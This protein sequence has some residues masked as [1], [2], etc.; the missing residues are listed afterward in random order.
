MSQA[1]DEGRYSIREPEFS[2][3]TLLVGGAFWTVLIGLSA[4]SLGMTVMMNG[5][6]E[7][8]AERMDGQAEWK[9][10]VNQWRGKVDAR[11]TEGERK[12]Y[13]LET[14]NPPA[15]GRRR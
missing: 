9:A 2:K 14:R 13:E 3:N 8:I 4:W 12:V 1:P 7:R 10:E 5:K 6:L 11:L 15:E